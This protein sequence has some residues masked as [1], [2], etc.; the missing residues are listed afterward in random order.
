[1]HHLDEVAGAGRTGMN[2]AAFGTG[3]AFRTARRTRNIAQPRSECCE[4]RIEAI[5][6][7]LRAAD[8]HAVAAIYPPDAAGRATVDVANA[9]VGQFFGATDIVFVE[10]VASVD[11]YVVRL[12]QAAETFHRLF[13]DPPGGQHHPNRA[14]LFLKRLDQIFQRFHRRG[15]L[16]RQR[17]SRLNIGVEYDAGVSCLH[18]AAG[19]VAAHATQADDADLHLLHSLS[20]KAPYSSAESI[21][22]ASSTKPASTSL[23]WIRN[24]RRPRS[25]STSRSPLACAAFTTP[26]L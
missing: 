7:L 6:G 16:L 17:L 23:R 13:G 18:Q 8:H 4:D 5:H 26:K 21:A 25:T 15:A 1:M 20:I 12:Q 2:I 24:A 9:L 10:R 22:P 19:H 14:R 3:I 11:D